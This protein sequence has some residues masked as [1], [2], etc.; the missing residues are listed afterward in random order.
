[1]C[2]IVLLP[3]SPSLRIAVDKKLPDIRSSP[4]LS[5]IAYYMVA[6]RWRSK[7][8]E[9]CYT[10]FIRWNPPLPAC[11]FLKPLFTPVKCHILFK[12]QKY[13]NLRKSPDLYTY[14]YKLLPTCQLLDSSLLE[15]TTGISSRT[16]QSD[17]VSCSNLRVST[18]FPTK[19]KQCNPTDC[20]ES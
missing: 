13:E 17:P 5:P 9:S 6:T 7:I 14:L 18:H 4:P 2:I 12:R 10:V 1:M 11:I 15:Q 8:R 16:L 19:H 20:P 3:C